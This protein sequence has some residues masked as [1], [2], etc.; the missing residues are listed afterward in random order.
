MSPVHRYAGSP[1]FP[2]SCSSRMGT[3]LAAA[4][5]QGIAGPEQTVIAAQSGETVRRAL[6]LGG[7]TRDW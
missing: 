4:E 7:P 2:G 5:L 1:E 3:V 6:Q